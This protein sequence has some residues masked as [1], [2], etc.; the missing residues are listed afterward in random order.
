MR[1]TEQSSFHA[2]YAGREQGGRKPGL[3][4]RR[5]LREC[6]ARSNR[7]FILVVKEEEHVALCRIRIETGERKWEKLQWRHAKLKV[8]RLL[9][10]RYMVTPEGIS[11]KH[12]SIRIS[13]KQASI[14]YLYRTIS[15]LPGKVC[16][17]GFIF[18]STIPR[19]SWCV[20]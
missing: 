20:S 7:A 19:I 14:R 6:G 2:N 5:R 13:K 11:W 18:R 8:L 12:I 17:G 1:S 3:G 4:M 16:C 9:P 15:L 10:L